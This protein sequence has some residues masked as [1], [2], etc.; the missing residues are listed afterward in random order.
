[1]SARILPYVACEQYDLVVTVCGYEE[2]S[3]G[4][5]SLLKPS[6]VRKV[7]IAYDTH[8]TLSF[9]KNKL[10]FE[11]S[12]YDV[13]S[14]GDGEFLGFLRSEFRSLVE[15]N[16]SSRVL[17][18]ISCL[19][20]VRL[21]SLIELCDQMRMRRVDFYYVLARYKPWRGTD[22]IHEFVEPIG[23]FYSGW[24]GENEKPTAL[25]AGLG[26]ENMRAMGVIELLDAANVWLFFP[27]S[28]IGNYDMDVAR[29]NALLLRDADCT[30]VLDYSVTDIYALCRDLFSLVGSLRQEYRC[31]MLPL[32]PKPFALVCLLAGTIY[33]DISVWRVSAGQFASPVDKK[34]SKF[35]IALAVSFSASEEVALADS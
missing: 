22:S 7:A 26:Y 34:P 12:G 33:R 35:S 5:L 18:D 13:L 9:D 8:H 11:R 15:S 17:I 25:V 3:R 24:T 23:A 4:I 29:A 19:T 16:L 2:R 21:G 14:L 6:G 20:R 31:S 32:G 10:A 30:R 28:S 1:V 27:R